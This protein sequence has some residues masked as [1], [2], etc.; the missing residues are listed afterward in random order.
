[1]IFFRKNI[2]FIS[3]FFVKKKR[4]IIILLFFYFFEF[5]GSLKSKYFI[6]FCLKRVDL[7]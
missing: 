4:S 1:M 6:F 7:I 5:M 2:F 3:V